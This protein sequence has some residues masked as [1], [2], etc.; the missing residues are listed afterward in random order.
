MY[1]TR[2]SG[3]TLLELVVVVVAV[4]GLLLV[5]LAFMHP[6][7]FAI[8]NRNT[9]RQ[10]GTA[11]MLQLV[12]RYVADHGDVPPGVTDKPLVIGSQPDELNLCTSFVPTYTKEFPTDPVT[13]GVLA[14]DGQTKLCTEKDVHFST[15]YT[16]AKA[17]DGTVTIAAPDA[18]DGAKVEISRKF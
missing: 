2:Q 15:G 17:K 16:I 6:K 8:T 13:G 10:L 1:R 4:S 7:N 9:E 18:E 5:A 12:T 3:F 14:L 11:Q